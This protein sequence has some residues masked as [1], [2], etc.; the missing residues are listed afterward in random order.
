MNKS[1]AMIAVALVLF[2]TAGSVSATSPQAGAGLVGTLA[3]ERYRT[4]AN[5][6]TYGMYSYVVAM[7]V[8]GSNER[9]LTAEDLEEERVPSWSPDGSR[10]AYTAGPDWDLFITNSDGGT[11]RRLTHGKRFGDWWPSWAPDGRRLVFYR[12]DYQEGGTRL[13]TIRADGSRMKALSDGDWPDAAPTWSPDGKWIAFSRYDPSGDDVAGFHIW[14]VRPDGTG[15]HRLTAGRLQAWRPAWSPDGK[16]IAFGG[17]KSEDYQGDVVTSKGSIYVIPAGGG[18]ARQ[19]T[20]G[21]YDM[22]PCWAPN[23]EMVAFTRTVADVWAFPPAPS[24]ANWA[25]YSAPADIYAVDLDGSGLV[26]LTNTPVSEEACTW[27]R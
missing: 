9:V 17:W 18:K 11:P 8:D 2:M 22:E 13:F 6:E 26:Q 20:D 3:F 1:L 7:N 27:T 24:P 10:L 5:S 4:P 25:G 14:A 16:W 12:T 15:L 23:S 19:I 21:A